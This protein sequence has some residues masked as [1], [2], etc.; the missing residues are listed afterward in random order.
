VNVVGDVDLESRNANAVVEDLEKTF[1]P[2]LAREF[3]DVAHYMEGEQ[4]EQSDTLAAMRRGSSIALLAIYALLAIPLRS[5]TQPLL[6]MLAIPF[7]LIG[8]VVGHIAL[9]VILSMSSLMGMVALAGVVVNDSLVLVS[10]INDQR[11]NGVALAT[12]IRDAGGARFRPILLTSLTTFAGLV[13]ILFDTSYEA[14]LLRP[15]A[16]SLAF[17]VL[18]ATAVTLLLVPTAYTILNDIRPDGRDRD[19]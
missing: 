11:A 3:P 1:L 2:E 10:Y 5:Y 19:P 13:P 18:L 15:M 4:R 17:G 7:G 16:I 8:A 6:I 12:A 9:G 14:V